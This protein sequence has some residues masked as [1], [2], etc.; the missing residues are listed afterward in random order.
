MYRNEAPSSPR[1]TPQP[2]SNRFSFDH[3]Q[4]ASVTSEPREDVVEIASATGGGYGG[5]GG[6]TGVAH[7]AAITGTSLTGTSATSSTT[8]SAFAVMNRFQATLF[9][10]IVALQSSS[11]QSSIMF[12]MLTFVFNCHLLW[13]SVFIPTVGGMNFGEYGEWVF[14]V[15]NY[16]LT[17]SLNLVP[18]EGMVALV[19]IVFATLLLYI[20]LLFMTYQRVINTRRFSDWFLQATRFFNFLIL[21]ACGTMTFVLTSLLECSSSITLDNGGSVSAIQLSRYSN[22]DCYHTPNIIFYAFSLVAFVIL[23]GCVALSAM[24]YRN[25]HPMNKSLFTS[26]NNNALMLQL[27][28]NC[29]EIMTIFLIP[30]QMLQIRAIVHLLFSIAFPPLFLSNLPYFRMIANSLFVGASGA[31]IGAS[32]GVVIS[33]FVN[34]QNSNDLGL[35]LMAVT[36]GLIVLGFIVGFVVMEFFQRLTYKQVEKIVNENK[37]NLSQVLH[38]FENKKRWLIMYL[39]FSVIRPISVNEDV[40]L[41]LAKVIGANKNQAQQH[42]FLLLISAL[43]IAYTWQD[44]NSHSF[45]MYMFKRCM[46]MSNNIFVR[47]QVQQRSKEVELD[48]TSASLA[49]KCI[50]ESKHVLDSLEKFEDE[51]RTLHRMFWKELM[52]DIPND[53]KIEYINRRCADLTSHI[54]EMYHNLMRKYRN[55]KTIIRKYANFVEVFR[56]DKETAQSLFAEANELEEEGSKY[57]FLPINNNVNRNL[58][59]SMVSQ[60]YEQIM[61]TNIEGEP[62][63]DE[64][65]GIETKEFSKKDVVL[66]NSLRHL[67][68]NKGFYVFL[69]LFLLFSFFVLLTCVT[70]SLYGSVKSGTDVQYVYKMCKG[71]SVSFAVLRE[72]RFIQNIN[73]YNQNGFSVRDEKNL[74]VD[75]VKNSH[76]AH[77]MTYKSF[78]TDIVEIA[79]QNKLNAVVYAELVNNSISAFFPFATT[80]LRNSSTTSNN[81]NS[82]ELAFTETYMKNSSMIEIFNYLLTGINSFIQWPLD[83][84]NQTTKD[85]NFMYLWRNKQSSRDAFETF[86]SS[87]VAS[88]ETFHSDFVMSF[89]IVYAAL[90]MMYIIGFVIFLGVM[91]KMMTSAKQVSKLFNSALSKNIIGKVYHDLG[92]KND[93]DVKVH[94][95]KYQFTAPKYIFL[96][97]GLFT[98]LCCIVSGGVMVVE[99]NLNYTGVSMTMNNVI[100][101]TTVMRHIHLSNFKVGE[102]FSFLASPPSSINDPSLLKT[103]PLTNAES[104][105][106]TILDELYQ[107]WNALIYGGISKEGQ[108]FPPS[109]GKYTDIDR[110]VAGIKNCTQARVIHNNS[111]TT[112]DFT[113]DLYMQR[114]CTGLDEMITE[115]SKKISIFNSESQNKAFTSN[116]VIMFNNY[117]DVFFTGS[118]LGEKI[119]DFMD[120]FVKYSAQ[121]SVIITILF[122]IGCLVFMIAIFYGM[123][124]QLE[125]H[126]LQLINMRM[127]LNYLPSEIIVGNEQ[128][129]N[130]ILYNILTPTNQKKTKKN[131]IHASDSEHAN[132]KSVL[133][134]SVDGAILCTKDGTIEFVNSSTQK[135]FGFAHKA[136]VVGVSV[137][138]LFDQQQ[139]VLIQNSIKEMN[140]AQIDVTHSEVIESTCLRK[141][142]TKFPVKINIFSVMFDT[143]IPMIALIIR[144]ITAEKKQ[145]AVLAEE[146]AKSDML[147]KN[148]LPES[149]AERLKSGE[150]FI[151]ERFA[152]ITCFFSDMVGFTKLSSTMNPSQLVGMLNTIVNGFDALTDTYQLEKIKT[153]G[154]AYFCVGGISGSLTSDHPERVLQFAIAT[155][156]VIREFNMTSDLE[157]QVEIRIGIN[158]GGV[159]AGVI[160]KKKFTFDIWGDTINVASRMESTGVPGRIHISRSTY[161]RV[162]D[163]GLEFEERRVEVKGK[164][165]CKTYLLAAKHHEQSIVTK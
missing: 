123:L 41:S 72:L 137:V 146:K 47:F 42:P 133:N 104:E 15:A 79:Q 17:L 150:T 8:L 128:L 20:A 57:N 81:N 67:E 120:V 151:A 51:L 38:I 113:I 115:Y 10:L 76:K 25:S 158:T 142:Q 21:I 65:T 50:T 7:S 98:L 30:K 3:L 126:R 92:L 83:Q 165:E 84:Y 64:F 23:I 154:D 26:L 100:H 53:V 62:N 14:T 71:S 112:T 59:L 93:E 143:G 9:S 69:V 13:V 40:T 101:G 141:N 70:I 31:K 118:L 2:R 61:M 54:E 140:K 75:L 32:I 19:F 94:L 153:I 48:E 148:I 163:M 139:S 122:G 134:A 22:V 34:S 80:I 18:Y 49:L 6:Q 138:T 121:P 16:P 45:A 73:N 90:I 161:E 87:I 37:E 78:I 149:V 35:Y 95:P 4:T 88:T 89:A 99:S 108:F 152:D 103:E 43:I 102:Y 86:C 63:N 85:F 106:R 155:F 145:S 131:Q 11:K 125:K 124:Y 66:K 136:D 132:V 164:G 46:K 159:V 44:G 110:L 39:Q 111:T 127:M 82:T 91:L 36:L 55:E 105:V 33:T 130:Y 74:V 27:V 5:A 116:T 162:H 12:W 117:M 96:M 109:I 77:L 107:E 160:G 60:R 28:L 29:L 147:L 119:I 24:I 56:F 52:N 97:M 58:R 156:G 157:T 114:F 144:D 68:N 135:M 1:G 129:R